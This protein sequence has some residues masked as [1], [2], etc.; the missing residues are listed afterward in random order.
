MTTVTVLKLEDVMGVLLRFHGVSPV[1]LRTMH[2]QSWN[3][4]RQM[5]TDTSTCLH[6]DCGLFQKLLQQPQSQNYK[7][8]KRLF[9]DPMR[10]TKVVLVFISD[11][12]EL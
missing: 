6:D 10:Y 4:L 1:M 9:L 8:Q 11:C 2:L 7:T 12:P 5:L 3:W